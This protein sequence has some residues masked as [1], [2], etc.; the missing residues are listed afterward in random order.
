M[1]SIKSRITVKSLFMYTLMIVSGILI[2]IFSIQRR[3]PIIK[4][5]PCLVTLLVQFFNSKANRYAKV[6]GGINSIIYAIGFFMDGLWGPFLNALLISSTLQFITFLRWNKNKYK[7]GTIYRKL[8]PR[9]KIIVYISVFCVS[10]VFAR[11]FQMLPNTTYPELNGVIFGLSLVITFLLMF[12]V[13]DGVAIN[14][15]NCSL[16]LAM[17]IYMVV[18][19]SP[20]NLHYIVIMSYSVISETLCFF[21]WQ[22]LY[23]EQTAIRGKPLLDFEKAS[24]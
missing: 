9:L 10:I 21:T 12:A 1:E 2:I 5:I 4:V 14:I 6:I 3:A 22:K 20:E 7:Q 8:S 17:Y 24:L 11:I 15:L 18:T 23:K 16:S 19:Q 13:I